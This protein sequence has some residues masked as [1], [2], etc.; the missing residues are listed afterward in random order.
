[1]SLVRTPEPPEEHV[2]TT[3]RQQLPTLLIYGSCVSRDAAAALPRGRHRL[4]GYIARQSLLSAGHP[5]SEHLPEELG[6]QHA[7]QERMVRAD[8]AGDVFEQIR[9][10]AGG[11]GAAGAAG[12]ASSGAGV[13]LLLWDLTDERHGVHW[14]LDGGVVTRSVDALGSE[15]IRPLLDPDRRIPFGS[16]LHLEGWREAAA[17][18]KRLLEDA[19]L[20]EKTVVLEVPWAETT[21]DGEP[22][23]A[24]MGLEPAEANRLYKPYYQAVR[25]LGFDV[26]TVDQPVHA[27]PDHQWGL[28]PFHYA[29]DVYRRINEGLAARLPTLLDE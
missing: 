26:L 18:F 23:P 13:D 22:V 11:S 29:P 28:A 10:A 25:E 24:S 15:A 20:F 17:E 5:A 27:D 12:A 8:F 6:L 19:G 14:F 9:G 2:P 3:P 21:D 1:M 4:A 16:E 7:F